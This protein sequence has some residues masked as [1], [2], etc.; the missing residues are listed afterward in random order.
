MSSSS[1]SGCARCISSCVIPSATIATTVATGNRRSRMHGTPAI[2]SG[3]VEI[4]SKTIGAFVPDFT[5][6]E[7]G[8]TSLAAPGDDHL[9]VVA[10]LGLVAS[11]SMS[12][13]AMGVPE[14]VVP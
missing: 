4:R 7:H 3:E 8:P 6:P 11:F 1:R 10:S 14:A 5:R 13:S 2:R 9:G 12:R